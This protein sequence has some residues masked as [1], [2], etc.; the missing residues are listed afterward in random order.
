MPDDP[1]QRVNPGEPVRLSARAWNAFLEAA[2]GR[3]SGAAGVD[4]SL[5]PTVD[6]L[7][8]NGT[9]GDLPAFRVLTPGTALVAVTEQ[10]RN[11]PRPGFN[12]AA[13]S[14]TTS[15]FV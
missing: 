15:A 4:L 14:A 1:L 3:E 12:G 11:R 9:G 13:P 5:S 2:N 10:H 7:I 8:K 6:V